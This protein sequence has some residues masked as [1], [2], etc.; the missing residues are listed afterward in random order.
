[1]VQLTLLRGFL[2]ASLLSLSILQ[3]LCCPTIFQKPGKHGTF[4]A[5]TSKEPQVGTTGGHAKFGT[6]ETQP[7]MPFFVSAPDCFCRIRAYREPCYEQSCV[8]P[9]QMKLDVQ[10]FV[11][12]SR[13]FLNRSRLCGE[14]AT[15]TVKRLLVAL[16][17]EV[18]SSA[19]TCSFDLRAAFQSLILE[20]VCYTS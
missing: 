5:F 17:L 3:P 12:C 11:D 18:S 16:R 15:W 1:M 19:T 2:Q 10:A 6:P 8:V 13:S 7:P 9:G 4:S 14:E 20:A